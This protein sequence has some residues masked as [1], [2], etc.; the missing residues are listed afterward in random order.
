MRMVLGVVDQH[1][2]KCGPRPFA[3]GFFT[4]HPPELR[5]HAPIARGRAAA[6]LAHHLTALNG[7]QHVAY[8]EEFQLQTREGPR[9]AA[10]NQRLLQN[11]QSQ[12]ARRAQLEHPRKRG[13]GQRAFARNEC[14]IR[15]RRIGR[16]GGLEDLYRQQFRTTRPRDGGARNADDRTENRRMHCSQDHC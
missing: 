12:H 2:G 14:R 16:P 9:V 8:R 5:N 7:H 6:C 11:R 13:R 4:P 10:L 15:H 3:V 1:D